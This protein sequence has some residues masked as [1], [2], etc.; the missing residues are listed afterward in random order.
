MTPDPT[1]AE[2]RSL[3][4]VVVNLARS[5]E[6]RAKMIETLQ[7][8]SLPYTFFDAVEGRDGHPLFDRFDPK[9]AEIRRGFILNAGELGC[10]ASHYLLWERCVREKRPL[11]IFEDDVSVSDTFPQAYQLVAE[12]IE[13]YGLLRLSGHKKRSFHVCETTQEGMDIIRFK[14]GP[15]GTSCYAVAPW[16]AAKLIAKADVWF[17]PVDVH[18]DRFW[19]HGVGSFGL[20]PMP[21]THVAETEE[22]SEIWQGKKRDRKSRRFRK[23]RALYRASD[24]IG[25]FIFNLPYIGRWVEG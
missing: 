7:P 16:A 1:M 4:I 11:L 3:E 10:F 25:R 6:R 17:E 24:D 18:L 13:R 9:L 22:Q 21:V 14:I 12:K 15:H 5:T 2:Q 8:F 19:T 23:L 20:R